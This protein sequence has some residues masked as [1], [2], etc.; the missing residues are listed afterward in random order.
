MG[1]RLGHRAV[2]LV[3]DAYLHHLSNAAKLQQVVHELRLPVQP[4]RAQH[5]P[6]V[7]VAAQ[8]HVD[9]VRYLAGGGEEVE[10]LG[11]VPRSLSTRG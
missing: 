11:C 6:S 8:E 4:Q 5:L 7:V 10:H 3:H 2:Q 9:V 1:V